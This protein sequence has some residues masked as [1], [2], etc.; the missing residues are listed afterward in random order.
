MG[1]KNIKMITEH[2][3]AVKVG[4][5]LFS[6]HWNIT[7]KRKAERLLAD[8][9]NGRRTSDRLRDLMEKKGAKLVMLT[10]LVSKWRIAK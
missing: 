3:I 8:Y 10:R 1:T 6:L 9:K 4:R 2:D 7:N 5:T